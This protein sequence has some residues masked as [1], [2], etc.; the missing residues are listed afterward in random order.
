MNSESIE[1][2]KLLLRQVLDRASKHPYNEIRLSHDERIAIRMAH[3]LM[4]VDDKHEDAC[5]NCGSR[6]LPVVKAQEIR[7]RQPQPAK[8]ICPDCGYKNPKVI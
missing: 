6:K 2:T 5:P 3:D 4:G 1:Q 8:E 7:D